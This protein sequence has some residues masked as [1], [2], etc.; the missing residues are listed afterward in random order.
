MANA[1]IAGHAAAML[2]ALTGNICKPGANI[3]VFVGGA[4]NGYTGL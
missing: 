3:G 4:W 2:A 1:D